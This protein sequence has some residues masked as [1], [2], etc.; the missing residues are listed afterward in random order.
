M[1]WRRGGRGEGEEFEE[2]EEFKEFKER[3][4]GAT[5]QEAGG[6]RQTRP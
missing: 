6:M 2:F 1:C 3:D 5:I 4:P